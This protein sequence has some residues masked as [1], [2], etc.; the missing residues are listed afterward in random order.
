MAAAQQA[1][2]MDRRKVRAEFER[3]FTAARMARAYVTAYRAFLAHVP[4]MPA[5]IFV[6]NFA[7]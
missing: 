2:Y 4:A 7:T 1:A 6:P 5:D 3:R